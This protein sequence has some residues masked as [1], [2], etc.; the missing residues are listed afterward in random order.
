[1]STQD[2]LR[3]KRDSKAIPHLEQYAQVWLVDDIVLPVEESVLFDVVFQH[4]LYGWVR[5]RY[6]YDGFNDVLYYRG[7]TVLSE[8]ETLNIQ[9]NPPYIMAA[10]PNVPNAYGG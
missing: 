2:I 1:M 8:V 3:Q 6:R 4:N 10:V 5:R 7:Q 9:E